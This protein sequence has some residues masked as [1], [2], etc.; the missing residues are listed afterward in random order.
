MSNRLG[1]KQGT[2]YTGTNANQPP[3]WTFNDRDPNQYDTNNYSIGDLW[4][5]ELTKVP[6]MLVDLQGSNTS[7]GAL[8]TWI[9]L[10]GGVGSGITNLEGDSGG[11]VFSNGASTVFVKGD[12]STISVDGTPGM[13]LLTISAGTTV[14]TS[15][16]TNPATGTAIPS[17][18][19]ITFAGQDGIVA[20]AAGSTIT[21]SSDGS[22]ANSFITN[23]ATGTAT[24]SAGVLTFAGTG[25]ITASAA[26]STVTIS[27]SGLPSG[28][29][30][31]LTGDSGGNALPLAGVITVAG[32]RNITTTANINPHTVTVDVSG[33]TNH[34][35]QI[36]NATNSL[37]SVS[38]SATSGVPFISQGAAAD[39]IFGTAVVAG[40][41][42]G[43]VST[44]A[45]API[46]GGTTSTNPLQ[47]ASTGIANVGYVLT[48]TGAG[49]LPDWE[50]VP[51]GGLTGLIGGN[52]NTATPTLG[53]IILANGN[54]ISTV[55]T[56][57]PNTVTINVAGTTD[58]AVQVG[59]A[60]GSLTSVVPSGTPGIPLVSTGAATNPAFGTAVVPGGGTGI[61]AAGAAYAPICAGT[62]VNGAFQTASTGI[63]NSGYV[64]TSNGAGAL[65]SWKPGSTGTGSSAFGACLF[66]DVANVTGAGFDYTIKFPKVAYN[67]GGNYN[68]GTGVYTAPANG[69]Y[70]FN[71]TVS[72]GSITAAM[73]TIRFALD[74]AGTG[75]SV[76]TVSFVRCNP[77]A[78]KSGA[79]IW[80]FNGGVNMY[81]NAGDIVSARITIENGAGNTASILGVAPAADALG[82]TFFTGC[83]II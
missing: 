19:V 34:A 71:S 46:C 31:A 6:Y 22:I 27:G 68:S 80:R 23:P 70:M 49:S 1:G 58:H 40:G 77:Y 12:G 4:L 54:N 56:A 32:R 39:P 50:P 18:N 69:L 28:T 3:N 42:T 76:G 24:P 81:L 75:P 8:A 57:G 59:N 38:P 74:V 29:V 78:T 35:V 47:S 64:L 13:N 41:G 51:G 5:N 79:D 36:G 73:T 21:L 7:K 17:M 10:T 67:I 2:S 43:V 55:A 63:A 83:R 82:R 20:A 52:G 48:S 44:T 66:N 62:V 30:T 15:F 45:Y 72:M 14:P 61:T 9:P 11:M 25:G 65:P 60:G 33:T 16:I 53:K 26:G 37:T